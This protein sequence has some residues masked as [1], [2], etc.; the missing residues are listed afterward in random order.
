MSPPGPAPTGPAIAG[1][2]VAI[3]PAQ[4]GAKPGAGVGVGTGGTGTAGSRTAFRTGQSTFGTGRSA[5]YSSGWSGTE[6]TEGGSS[7]SSFSSGAGKTSFGGIVSFFTGFLSGLMPSSFGGGGGG[8]RIIVQQAPQQQP[9]PRTIVILQPPAPPP[10]QPNVTSGKTSIG[11]T[12]QPAI[13]GYDNVSIDT[14]EPYTGVNAE[15]GTDISAIE[16]DIRDKGG[17]LDRIVILEGDL[18]PPGSVSARID[19]SSA[20]APEQKEKGESNAG[21]GPSAS[22]EGQEASDFGTSS[23]IQIAKQVQDAIDTV[24]SW[25]GQSEFLSASASNI[26]SPP[27]FVSSVAGLQGGWTN[28]LPTPVD[29][30]AALAQ[31]EVN[32]DATEAQMNALLDFQAAGLCG[33]QCIA[34][35]MTLD[36]QREVQKKQIRD[37]GTALDEQLRGGPSTPGAP[38]KRP[39]FAEAPGNS[40]EPRGNAPEE[41]GSAP[42]APGAGNESPALSPGWQE[43]EQQQAVEPPSAIEQVSQRLAESSPPA[44]EREFSA[45]AQSA[46]PTPVQESRTET[47]VKRVVRTVWS[48]LTSFF[49]PSPQAAN[50]SKSCSLFTSLFGGCT[51]W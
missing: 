13:P 50:R 39:D 48:A 28:Q 1:K 23:R 31:L 20:A 5:S 11:K 15:P 32:R 35:L 14:G 12:G 36:A 26:G 47:F 40:A 41:R 9:P 44:A 38:S 16:K 27:V 29:K 19:I 10:V 6:Q 7:G 30:K 21:E 45:R 4:P 51:G 18:P 24:L 37:L 17:Q 46:T 43:P 2:P 8:T 49:S 3:Q 25:T 42:A 33:P 22:L 34:T